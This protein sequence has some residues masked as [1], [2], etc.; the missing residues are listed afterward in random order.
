MPIGIGNALSLKNSSAAR[1][2]AMP[3]TNTPCLPLVGASCPPPAD[4]PSPLLEGAQRP[5]DAGFAPTGAER[6]RV[7]APQVL[8]GEVS[9][10]HPTSEVFSISADTP[11]HIGDL[12]ALPYRI[13]H[14]AAEPVCYR[15]TDGKHVFALATDLG[16]FD[17][18]TVAHLKNADVLMLEANHDVRML[19]TGPYPYPLKQ[20][21]LGDKGHLSNDASGTLLTSVLHDN[22]KAVML[23]HLS[24]C[25]NLPQL[26]YETVRLE[27]EMG[28]TPYHATDFKLT[29]AK[30]HEPSQ[31]IAL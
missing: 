10:A 30:R 27:I 1:L 22:L 6:R 17:D 8:T 20:R 25:N 28:D 4:A 29:V 9:S 15:V 31:V 2:S 11:F 14:D 16:Y 18:Y 7:A 19:Q 5:G 12:T 3:H 13:S 24:E 23:G 26:A 21:I